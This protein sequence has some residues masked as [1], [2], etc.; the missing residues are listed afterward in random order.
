[1]NSQG[2][3]PYPSK[4][5]QTKSDAKSLFRIAMKEFAGKVP[6]S[7]GE[8]ACVVGDGKNGENF[9]ATSGRPQKPYVGGHT[10]GS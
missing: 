8:L 5:C 9:P 1:M 3:I 6:L 10:G 4:S 7:R 2:D